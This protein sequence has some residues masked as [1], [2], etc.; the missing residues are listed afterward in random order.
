MC[1]SFFLRIMLDYLMPQLVLKWR[2]SEVLGLNVEFS[3]TEQT[4]FT[5]LYL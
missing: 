2:T 5:D 3:V 4:L 1:T